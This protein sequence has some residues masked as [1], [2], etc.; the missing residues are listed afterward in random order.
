MEL[1]F[2]LKQLILPPG[3][4]MLL[5]LLAWLLWAWAGRPRLAVACLLAGLGGCGCS[6]CRPWWS[7]RRG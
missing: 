5:I 4:L 6:V 2:I 7:G 3:G 1:R